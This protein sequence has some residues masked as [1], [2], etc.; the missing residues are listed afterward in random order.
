ME[1]TRQFRWVNLFRRTGSEGEYTRAG[2]PAT[3][4]ERWGINFC[5]VS[6]DQCGQRGI[7]LRRLRT[8]EEGPWIFYSQQIPT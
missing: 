8:E 6:P 7:F 4:H 3:A 2:I 5:G 1:N